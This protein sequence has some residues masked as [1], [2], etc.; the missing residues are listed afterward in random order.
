[1]GTLQSNQLEAF[2]RVAQTKNFT[3]ASEQLH[4][5]QSALSQRIL[6]LEEELGTTLFIRDRSGLRLTETANKLVRFCLAKNDLENDFLST[7]KASSE[8]TGIVRIGGFSSVLRSVVLPALSS[9]LN[10][11]MDVQLMILTKEISELYDLLKTG[12]VDFIL[13]DHKY[14]RDEFESIRLG[15]E[16][17][18]LVESKTSKSCD[19]YLDH[20]PSDEITI[21]YLRK[22]GIKDNKI[23]RRYL[24]DVYGLIDGVKMGLG[25]AVLPIHL[26]KDDKSLRVVNPKM[27]LQT[28]VYLNFFKQSYY[29]KLHQQTLKEITQGASLILNKKP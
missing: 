21:K 6:N 22:N 27:F 16:L 1:M 18:V 10:K 15:Y 29:S 28:E 20:D 11:H 12:E 17:N 5:T 23:K 2:F 24:D 14:E 26:I 9:F 25:R 13:T 4:I 19:I 8:Y 3:K 7:L